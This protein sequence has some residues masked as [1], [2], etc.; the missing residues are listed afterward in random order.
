M[1]ATSETRRTRTMPRRRRPPRGSRRTTAASTSPCARPLIVSRSASAN[2]GPT[3]TTTSPGPSPAAASP[4]FDHDRAPTLRRRR[5]ELA[6]VDDVRQRLQQLP[7]LALEP[8]AGPGP[9]VLVRVVDRRAHEPVGVDHR[10]RSGGSRPRRAGAACPTTASATSAKPRAVERERDV[11]PGDAAARAA[12]RRPRRPRRGRDRA[13]R[14]RRSRRRRARPPRRVTGGQP[15]SA[16]TAWT[17]RAARSRTR[18][19]LLLGDRLD[20][21][22][23]LPV[24]LDR[25]PLVEVVGVVVAAA[26]RVV[27]A[28]HHRVARRDEVRPRQELAHQLRRLADRGVRRDRVVA[29][30]DLEVEPGGDH[31]LGQ[32]RARPARHARARARRTRS[33]RSARPASPPRARAARQRASR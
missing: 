32:D 21:R 11:E 22:V 17:A 6:R 10:R 14:A 7:A 33:S 30:R 26:E 27:V 23:D 24:A 29:R 13:G 1:N 25:Q 8:V 3:A 4:S 2:A 18:V 20:P 12:R 31:V 9:R 19:D 16:N 15:S 28:R 5:A